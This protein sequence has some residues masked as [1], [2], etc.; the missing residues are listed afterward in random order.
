MAVPFKRRLY[1][2]ILR[3]FSPLAKKMASRP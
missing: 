1:G 2:N 3:E